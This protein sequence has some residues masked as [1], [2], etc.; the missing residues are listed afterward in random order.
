MTASTP[1]PVIVS[2]VEQLREAIREVVRDEFAEFG[3]DRPVA[4]LAVD[5]A[6]LCRLISVSRSTL[7]RLR[8]EGMPAIPVGD[9]YRYEPAACLE[10]L[11]ERASK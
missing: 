6:E 10:W 3:A 5:G 1:A 4:P 8:V 7:H 11:R 2:T 9:T